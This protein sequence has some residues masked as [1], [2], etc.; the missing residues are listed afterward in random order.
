MTA[1]EIADACIA[2]IS[3]GNIGAMKAKIHRLARHTLGGETRL[4]DMNNL[5][6][7]VI[8]RLRKHGVKI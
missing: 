5:K 3:R 7:A 2:T 8:V 1:R 6:H 4:T